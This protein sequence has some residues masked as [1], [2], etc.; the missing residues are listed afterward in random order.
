M[1]ISQRLNLQ[2]Y[3]FPDLQIYKFTNL[4]IHKF[5]KAQSTNLQF[6]TNLQIYRTIY[7]SGWGRHGATG[8][9]L[10]LGDGVGETVEGFTQFALWEEPPSVGRRL[11]TTPT[12]APL[13]TQS[14][15]AWT[16]KSESSKYQK[17]C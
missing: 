1:C 14:T 3:K 6:F 5:T 9:P 7:R 2:I 13:R 8:I 16:M 11:H 12:R 4:Q 15:R 17:Q 10:P